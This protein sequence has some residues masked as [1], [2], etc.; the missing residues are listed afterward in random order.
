MEM[1]HVSAVIVDKDRIL[2]ISTKSGSGKW[3]IPGGRARE[4][5]HVLR[6]LKRELEEE[7]GIDVEDRFDFLWNY[8]RKYPDGRELKG[9]CFRVWPKKTEVKL[10]EGRKNY[11]WVTVEEL[12]KYEM[13]KELKKDINENS[14][15]WLKR[16][17]GNP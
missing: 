6:A 16:P 7:C 17:G 2:L 9:F 15:K 5:E 14:W 11:A 1:F 13:N 3:T 12:G 4:D 10:E 8:T